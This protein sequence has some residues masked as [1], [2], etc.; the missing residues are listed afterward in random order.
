MLAWAGGSTGRVDIS[1]RPSISVKLTSF[2]MILMSA[3]VLSGN[4]T[5]D[6]HV[7]RDHRNRGVVWMLAITSAHIFPPLRYTRPLN[8][9]TDKL[10]V[11]SAA[12]EF[13]SRGPCFLFHAI[14]SLRL[15]A[16]THGLTSAVYITR[17]MD[18]W[19]ATIEYTELIAC[20]H[21]SLVCLSKR[22]CYTSLCSRVSSCCS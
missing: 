13:L 22:L 11:E 21:N 6:D 18:W 15:L 12:G 3:N 9:W 4:R 20:R 7:P 1:E 2:P 17:Y 8:S 10:F 14:L 5:P 16:L 19:I